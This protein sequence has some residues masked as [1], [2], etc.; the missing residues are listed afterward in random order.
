MMMNKFNFYDVVKVLSS[1]IS[2]RSMTG[3]EGVILG[4]S[5]NEELGR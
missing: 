3:C 4:M 1:K 5:Q 2:L